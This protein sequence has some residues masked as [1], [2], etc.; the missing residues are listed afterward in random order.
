MG[1]IGREIV[2]ECLEELSRKDLQQKR[3]LSV[4]PSDISS[5]TEVVEG[6]FTDSALG[7]ALEKG[8]TGYTKEDEDKLRALRKMLSNVDQ[9]R[10]TEEVINDSAMD[11]V[12]SAAAE[13]LK[14]LKG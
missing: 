5:F 14:S 11:K 12:R 2:I 1:W 13:L 7:Y 9:H 3:W 6:L 4:G 10:K 8:D